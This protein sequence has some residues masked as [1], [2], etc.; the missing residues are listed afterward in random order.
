MIFANEFSEKWGKAKANTEDVNDK[1]NPLMTDF[2]KKIVEE[3]RD[4]AKA[5]AAK[6][7]TE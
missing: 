3:A 4:E 6:S 2:E 7:K 5:E 1:D